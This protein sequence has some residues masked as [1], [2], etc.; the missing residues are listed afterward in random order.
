MGQGLEQRLRHMV[1]NKKPCWIELQ[2]PRSEIPN[3][4]LGIKLRHQ[5]MLQIKP[6]ND[7]KQYPTY[8]DWMFA[9]LQNSF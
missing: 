1:E 9:S 2:I 3:E 5:W 7:V 8:R 6:I 4:I